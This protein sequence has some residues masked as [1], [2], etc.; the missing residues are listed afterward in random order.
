MKNIKLGLIGLACMFLTTSTIG[1]TY[2]LVWE[3][4]F[5][6]TKLDTNYWS[7]EEKVG[8]WN[9]GQN[10]ELQHYRKENV[11]VGDDGNG[12]SS[13]IITAKREDYKGYSFTS[14]KVISKGKAAFKQGKIEAMIKMPDLKNGLWPAFWTL[15]YEPIGWPHCGEIDILEM[16]HTAAIAEDNVNNF[17]GAHLFWGNDDN[18]GFPN[19]GTELTTAEN[20]STGYFK[21]T[22]IWTKS[23]ISVYFNDATTPYFTMNITDAQFEEFRDYQHYLLFNMAVGGSFTGIHS[24]NDITATM[25]ANM[26]VDWVRVYQEEGLEDYNDTSLALF[27]DF[28]VYEEEAAVEM[29]MNYGFDLKDYVT[30]ATVRSGET[31]YDGE[32]CLSYNLSSGQAIDLRLK[33]GLTR[34]IKNYTDGSLQLYLK[35]DIADAISIGIADKDGTTKLVTFASGTEKDFSRDGTW[36]MVYVPIADLSSGLE[37]EE[38]MDMLVVKTTPSANG[39]ISIDQVV[40]RETVPAEGYYGIFTNNALIS[41]GFVV[42]NVN[43]NLYIWSNTVAFNEYWPAYEGEDVHSFKSTGAADWFGYGYH[44]KNALNFEAYANGYLNISVRTTSNSTFYIGMDTEGGT[45]AEI[46]FVAGSDPYG[47]FRDGEWHHLAIPMKDFT[48]KGLDLKSVNHVFKTGG[49]GSTSD[50]AYDNIFL[51]EEMADINNDGICYADKLTISP[52]N[53]SVGAGNS[54][55]FTATVLNQFG[56]K[57]DN[58]VSWSADGGSINDNGVFTLTE[59]GDYV[60][61]ATQENLT[62]TAEVTVVEATSTDN[63]I[64]ETLKYK[65]SRADEVLTISGLNGANRIMV[66]SIDGKVVH[67]TNSFD[68]E[69]QFAMQ[70]QANGVYIVHVLN[71]D[72]FRTIK[73]VK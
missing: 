34:N 14:G 73:F 8:I 31:S 2:K 44:S 29:Y 55:T 13:L 61:T 38:V 49:G 56:N 17:I 23:K 11:S 54:V 28:G 66:I 65:Y 64:S 25:P 67:S 37:L 51:S 4:N 70:N 5:D 68:E 71:G 62:A 22:L 30:G 6:G 27:G 24:P 53:T 9:T 58:L 46:N 15:G 52:T 39:Y 12:N 47:L 35:T 18:S 43:Y 60:V 10:A 48:D 42:D 50:I 26:Y 59:L 63:Y 20:L 16:G 7:I 1:Q 41:E 33:A 19:Y 57:F 36:Q 3:D 72:D 32:E 21:H 40:I 69:V 45:S